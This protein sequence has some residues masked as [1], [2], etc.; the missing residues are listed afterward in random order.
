[1]IEPDRVS[2]DRWTQHVL[3]IGDSLEGRVYLV[4]VEPRDTEIAVRLRDSATGATARLSFGRDLELH[5]ARKKI[6]AAAASL[7]A[8]T[9]QGDIHS[10][11]KPGR[12]KRA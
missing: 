12:R 11:T 5:Q 4:A 7:L 1:V 8:S 6:L 9:W 3:E 2:D 10:S